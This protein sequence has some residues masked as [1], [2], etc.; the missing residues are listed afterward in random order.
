M[1]DATFAHFQP[2][3]SLHRQDVYIH[4]HG[5]P[6]HSLVSS[7]C[8]HDLYEL[9][10]NFLISCCNVGG[11]LYSWRKSF[12]LPLCCTCMSLF[13]GMMKMRPLT[14][15]SELADVCLISSSTTLKLVCVTL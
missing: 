13:H 5:L 9:K 7:Y 8:I 1:G 4:Q 6:L 2:Y 12:L 14:E 15:L 3:H 11:Q 10:D